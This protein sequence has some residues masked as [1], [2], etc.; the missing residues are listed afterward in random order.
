M[1]ATYTDEEIQA[2]IQAAET[3]VGQESRT[4]GNYARSWALIAI[5]KLLFNKKDQ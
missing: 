3:H 1:P 4:S 2:H 5:A